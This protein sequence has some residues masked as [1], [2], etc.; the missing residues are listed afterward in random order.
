MKKKKIDNFIVKPVAMYYTLG[1][2]YIHINIQHTS[3]TTSKLLISL[4]Y[5]NND[6]K[7]IT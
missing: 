7:R 5:D 4:R 2:I 3:S 1:Y 6:V